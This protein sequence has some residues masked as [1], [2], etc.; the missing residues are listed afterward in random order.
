MD[1]PIRTG[2]VILFSG[3]G[4]VSAGI[5][6]RTWSRYSHIGMVAWTTADDV[7][8]MRD[9]GGLD[10]CDS[11]M[12]HLDAWIGVGKMLLYEST[13]QA[14]NCCDVLGRR[15]PGVQA[16]A[17]QD[18]VNAYDG[19]VYRLPWRPNFALDTK[20]RDALP[21]N[22]LVRLGTPYDPAGAGL[23]GSCVLKHLWRHDASD[24]SSVFCS[25]EVARQIDNLESGKRLPVRSPSRWTPGGLAGMLIDSERCDLPILM[26]KVA[27]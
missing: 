6:W 8:A 21:L 27:A 17:L 25:E 2:D 1:T 5:R 11:H 19:E 3:N 9:T 16:H 13:T 15:F 12:R 26:P 22:W 14:G 18:R 4:W 10:I 20:E 7:Q 24:R 23:L